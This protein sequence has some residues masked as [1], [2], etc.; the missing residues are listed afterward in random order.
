MYISSKPN[1]GHKLVALY[2]VYG[3][4][5]EC[6]NTIAYASKLLAF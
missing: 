6:W 1:T 2:A 4:V 5:S 3:A